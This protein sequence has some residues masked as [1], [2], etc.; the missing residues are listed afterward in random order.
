[1]KKEKGCFD[2]VSGNTPNAI[3]CH[4]ILWEYR[5]FRQCNEIFQ[6]DNI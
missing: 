1:M 4:Y 5:P 2:D 6:M 3:T